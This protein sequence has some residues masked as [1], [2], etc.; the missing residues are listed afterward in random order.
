MKTYLAG[1]FLAA[2]VSSGCSSPQNDTSDGNTSDTSLIGPTWQLAAFG[3]DEG[4]QPVTQDTEITA[5]FSDEGRIAGSA[6]CNRYFGSYEQ[7]EDALTISQVGS[8]RMACPEPLMNQEDRFLTAL[9]TVARWE[10]HGNRLDL[11]D[12]AG[13]LLLRFEAQAK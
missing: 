12:A 2:I 4:E 11:L 3:S 5:E 7:S 1:L 8:T 9:K 13:S 6:G 10:R